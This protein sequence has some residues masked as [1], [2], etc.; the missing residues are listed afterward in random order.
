MDGYVEIINDKPMPQF[1]VGRN[2]AD[3]TQKR[4]KQ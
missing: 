3:L 1:T 4:C 2:E